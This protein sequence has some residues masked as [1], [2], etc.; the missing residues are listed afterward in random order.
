MIG[1]YYR[2]GEC[3]C[4]LGW[5]E[6]AIDLRKIGHIC[7]PGSSYIQKAARQLGISPIVYVAEQLGISV[8]E[9][10]GFWRER[11]VTEEAD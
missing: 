2:C 1:S 6:E 7:N 8:E 5:A 3:F 11:G 10:A 4:G 9:V